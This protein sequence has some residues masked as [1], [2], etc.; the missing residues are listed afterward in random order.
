[1]KNSIPLIIL[2]TSLLLSCGKG[3]KSSK[4]NTAVIRTPALEEQA[5]EGSYRAILR[6]FNNHLSGFLP[7]GVAEIKI[8]G[9]SVQ[10]KTLLDDDARVVHIQSIHQG[11]ACPTIL[12]DTNKDGLI[13]VAE[14]IAIS[15]KVFISL[16][17]NLNSEEEGAGLYPFGGDFTYVENA[18]LSKLESDAKTRTG[19]G[20]NLSGRVVLIHGV[21]GAT[22]M[23]DSVATLGIMSRQAS[24]PIACGILKREL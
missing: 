19:Q 24:I 20:L 8:S 16:D 3:E 7:T 12:N 14:A 22:Q 11:T 9:D 4:S 23:P 5:A 1:M 21:N 18:S 17:G 13:D 15:G 2:T 6:P 10:V